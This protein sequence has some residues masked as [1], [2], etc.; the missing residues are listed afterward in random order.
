MLRLGGEGYVCCGEPPETRRERDAR[1]HESNTPLRMTR[2]RREDRERCLR[3][4]HFGERLEI[5]VSARAI[6][7]LPVVAAPGVSGS[8]RSS[9]SREE[10]IAR[11]RTE[12]TN[13]FVQPF[14]CAFS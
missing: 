2:L 6:V 4:G 7:Q 10:P 14:C 5:V 12:H 1:G 3:A 9:T 11:S 13:L 8:R